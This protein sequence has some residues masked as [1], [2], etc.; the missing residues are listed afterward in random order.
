MP[1]LEIELNIFIKLRET[2]VISFKLFGLEVLCFAMK[3]SSLSAWRLFL[4]LIVSLLLTIAWSWIVIQD[5]IV[6][7]YM[8]HANCVD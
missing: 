3:N 8:V 1:K 7:G 5:L 4:L 2:Y 6:D